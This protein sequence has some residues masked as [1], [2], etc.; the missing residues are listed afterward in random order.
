VPQPTLTVQERRLAAF[1]RMFAVLYF[2]GAI[3]LAV[4]PSTG[5]A[6]L[7]GAAMA[8]AAAACLVAATRPRERRHAVLPVA[9]AQLTACA[10]AAVHLI[11]GARS[12]A[13]MSVVA[14]GL[15]LLGLTL[16]MYRAAAPGVHSEPAREG[17]PLEEEPA[18]IQLKVSKS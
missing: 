1:C 13:L 16:A 4:L 3:C 10:V 7:E 2:A 12:L 15:P 6:A 5:I 11:G 9:A 17:P 18:K 8:G 14:I